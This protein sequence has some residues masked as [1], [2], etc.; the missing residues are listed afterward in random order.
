MKEEIL[1]TYFDFILGKFI[2]NLL[3]KGGLL[4]FLAKE[5]V[6]LII[7]CGEKKVLNG[8]DLKRSNLDFRLI[9]QKL[10]LFCKV[11]IFEFLEPFLT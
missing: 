4:N 8:R 10:D 6:I 3:F 1:G 9:A 11:P 2:L 7:S 5:E